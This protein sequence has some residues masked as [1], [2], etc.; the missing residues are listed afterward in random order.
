MLKP[1]LERVLIRAGVDSAGRALRAGHVLVLAYH[2]VVPTGERP[3]GDR[4]LHLP[5]EI[6]AHQLDQLCATHDV[7]PLDA[8]F[9]PPGGQRPRVVITFDDAYRGALTAGLA[10]VVARHLP[11]TVFVAPGILGDQV[12]WWDAF[13]NPATGQLDAAFRTVALTSCRG[14]GREV[15]DFAGSAGL[16]PTLVPEWARTA[17][18]VDLA[19]AQCSGVT[20]ASH[21]WTH[22]NLAALSANEIEEEVAKPLGWLR[23]RFGAAFRPWFAWP[24]GL[25]SATAEAT[26]M[27]AGYG[28]AFLVAG[29]FMTSRAARNRARLPRFNV[30]AGLSLAGF[31]LRTAG[32]FASGVLANHSPDSG[33]LV[34]ATGPLPR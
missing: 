5:Q 21:S 30:P 10:E 3:V 33:V 13:A 32:L 27:R 31:A 9:D 24:Y 12:L 2:N 7:V 14:L 6:F 8:I 17:R 1:I 23:A 11:M 16:R 34:R 19:R 26:A 4:S 25:S 15:S 20:F 28:G 22:A 29:S 18:D